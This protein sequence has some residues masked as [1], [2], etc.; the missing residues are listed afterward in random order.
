MK[1][2]WSDRCSAVAVA[3]PARSPSLGALKVGFLQ[4]LDQYSKRTS[5]L[6]CW[7]LALSH[8]LTGLIAGQS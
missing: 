1:G 8:R 3:V 5:V 7:S 4:L 2:D 6:K